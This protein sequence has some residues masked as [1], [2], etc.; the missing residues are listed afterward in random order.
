[1]AQKK[2]ADR[3]QGDNNFDIINSEEWKKLKK[4]EK[5][6]QTF[7]ENAPDII[8]ALNVNGD[9]SYVSAAWEKILGHSTDQVIGRYFSDFSIPTEIEMFKNFYGLLKNSKKIINDVDCTLLGTDGTS[10][11][12]SLSGSPLLDSGGNLSGIIG[13]CK[14]ITARK[15]A[16][17]ALKESEQ[18]H[19]IILEVASDPVIVYD[20]DFKVTYFNPAFSK[21]FDWT[22][23][24]C[25][26]RPLK[27][28]PDEKQKETE[29]M[30]NQLRTG[31][32]FSGIE[33]CRNTKGGRIVD[34]SISGAALLDH[35]GNIN[36]FVNNLQ[37]ITERRKKDRE[38]RYV[39]YHDQLTN[40]PNRKAFYHA[41]KN[42]LHRSRRRQGDTIWALMF[43][44]LNKFKQINDTMGHDFGDLLLKSVAKRLKICLRS[45]DDLFRLG[46]DEFTIILNQIAL[47]LDVAAV[48]RKIIQEISNAFSIE[49]QQI[50]TST[51]IGIS[52]FPD[53]GWDVESL[54][55][56]ADLAMYKAKEEGCGFRF[57]TSEM[58]CNAIERMNLENDLR[59][60]L[61]KNQFI[62]YYQPILSNHDKIIGIEALI[63]WQHP[64]KGLLLPDQFIKMA[65]DSGQIIPIGKWVLKIACIQTKKWQTIEPDLFVTINLS[66]RQFMDPIL[67][68]TIMKILKN[69][70]LSPSY[71]KL[72]INENSVIVNPELCITK[73]K[74][75][76]KKGITFTIDDFGG[77]STY[78]SYLK[79]LPIDILKIDQSFITNLKNKRDREIYKTIIALANKMDIKAVAEGIETSEQ[80]RFITNQGC[81]EM[82][83][84]F[85]SKPIPSE[86]FIK[87]LRKK[88]NK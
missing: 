54:V 44:D 25:Q 81:R 60:A 76:R 5:N 53:D 73:M 82:Q 29:K 17:T 48:A 57:F 39:A 84:Y 66:S 34:V 64:Q 32:S 33:T 2:A 38:L 8:Y 85:F 78:L 20:R 42:I 46:G 47:N 51:S 62:L 6:F 63:R 10:Y 22:L 79:H 11:Y 1:M 13:L 88:N 55:K 65:E 71:L 19:R 70:G 41:M 4:I 56:N 72:E 87:L 40:L 27:F 83:G 14:D 68:D 67:V 18:Q 50:H 9:F 45:S 58:H 15:A 36:G 37:D 80:H 52:V 21:V 35:F 24:E 12:F 30:L 7:S 86:K 16:Q 77:G 43:L 31:D 74:I 61:D 59:T 28:V 49:G 3:L 75:L 23:E 69:T 26:G